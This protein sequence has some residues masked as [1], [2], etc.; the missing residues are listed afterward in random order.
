MRRKLIRAA[1]V[2]AA[3]FALAGCGKKNDKKENTTA[4]TTVEVTEATTAEVTTEGTSED[5][6]AD[7]TEASTEATSE[8]SSDNDAGK[9]ADSSETVEAEE[10][11]D[12]NM[13][14][15]TADMLKDGEYDITGLSSS[16]MFKIVSAKLVVKD[17]KLTV[18]M[19][20]GEKGYLYVYP[21]TPEEAVAAAEDSYIPFVENEAGEHTFTFEIPALD[22]EVKCAAFSKKKEKWYDRSLCFTSGDL[23]LDAFNEDALS[24]AAKL[25]LADGKYT[26]D[27]ILAGGS[28]RASVESPAEIEVK[29]GEIY[30]TIRWSSSNYDYMIVD[31]EKIEAEIIDE[32]STFVIKVLAFDYRQAVVA[33]TTAMSKPHE[34]EY[35]LK[36]DSKS[37]ESK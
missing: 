30:A 5:T 18:T 21:G 19:T 17:G 31:G 22:S 12:A 1:L 14:P 27:V 28:G 9:I 20:M 8:N 13:S 34:I 37:I 26:A 23:P 36:F 24:T 29:D 33:D 32:K 4:S 2:A 15:I 11:V 7:T 6:T 10:V 25:E 35:S 3:V 16:S